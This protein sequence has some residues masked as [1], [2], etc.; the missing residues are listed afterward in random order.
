MTSPSAIVSRAFAAAVLAAVLGLL[1]EP[2][3]AQTETCGDHDGNGSVV[4]SDALRL[5]RFAVGQPVTLQCP[6]TSC[7]TST[8]TT[9]LPPACQT[10]AEESFCSI[11][12][13]QHC[14]D[15]RQACLADLNCACFT[16]CIVDTH[17]NSCVLICE[18]FGTAAENFVNCIKTNCEGC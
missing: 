4:S 15:E 9:T 8:T 3:S 17:P 16:E 5:L 12:A 6:E 11:C 10:S 1:P 18:P 7:T 13:R 2:V 14:C